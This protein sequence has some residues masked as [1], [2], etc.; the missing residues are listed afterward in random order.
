MVNQLLSICIYTF[1]NF[2]IPTDKLD[3]QVCPMDFSLPLICICLF[4]DLGVSGIL[5]M[6]SPFGGD[7]L[8]FH[9][10]LSVRPSVRPLSQIVPA[11]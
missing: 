10:C 8:I 9:C 2:I 11:L 4:I 1:T 6:T 7:I 5:I 3:L